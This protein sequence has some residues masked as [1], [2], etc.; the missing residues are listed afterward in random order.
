MPLTIIYLFFLF[1]APQLWVKPIIDFPAD[2]ILLPCWI[3]AVLFMK[4]KNTIRLTVLDTQ[5]ILMIAWNIVSMAINGFNERSAPLNIYYFKCFIVYKLVSITISNSERLKHVANTVIVFALILGIEGIIHRNSTSGLGW[6]GQTLGWIDPDA[7]IAG[8]PGRTRWISIFDGPGVFC[9]V[10]TIALPFVLQLINPSYKLVVR[11]MAFSITVVLL[12]A[13]YYTGSR[14]GFLTTIGV[15]SLFIALKYRFSKAKMLMIIG[16]IMLIFILAPSY[17]TTMNDQS[18]SSRHRVDMWAE[19]IEMVQQN[20]VF[21][22]GKGN[23]LKYTGA[24]YA[25][26]S[27]IEIMGETGLP[28]L[29]IWFGLIYMS[30]KCVMRYT[31]ESVDEHSKLYANA[32]GLSLIGY[33]MSSMFVTLEYET[34]YFLIGICSGLGQQLKNGLGITSKDIYI[35]MSLTIGWFLVIKTFVLLYS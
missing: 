8:V 23:Y 35:I 3:V 4:E 25:H 1:I 27:T 11:L 29:F 22:I 21:G 14:G 5:F 16:I 33:Y 13:I 20:P 2:M 6:A 7:M 26:N 12:L 32:L 15:A 28:G 31:K 24:L 17:L 34:H 19:G 9:V 18:G 10:F 30:I